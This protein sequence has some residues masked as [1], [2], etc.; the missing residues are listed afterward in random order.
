MAA[1][2]IAIN[3]KEYAA[4]GSYAEQPGA[5]AAR[6]KRLLYSYFTAGEC[7]VLVWNVSLPLQQDELPVRRAKCSAIFLPKPDNAAV[8]LAAAGTGGAGPTIMETTLLLAG[9]EVVAY[10]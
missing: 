9:E 5:E 6:P 4:D 2:M 1:H 8:P 3:G 7:L 10:K